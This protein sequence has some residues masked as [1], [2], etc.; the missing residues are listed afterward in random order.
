MATSIG[1]RS[2]LT[3][4]AVALTI[5][6]LVA[7]GSSKASSGASGTNN[8][9]APGVTSSEVKVAVIA[10]QTGPAAPTFA[11][12]LEGAKARFQMQNDAGGVKGRKVTVVVDDDQGDG[13]QQVVA[14]RNAVQSQKV[15]G[16]VAASRVDTM[17]DYLKQQNVP[18]TG[19][20]GQP[21]YATNMNTFGFAGAGP[22]GYVSTALAQR[23]K[24]SGATNVANLA[25]NSPGS[26]NS[27]KGFGVSA[28][29]IGLKIGVEQ[30]DIPLGSF[31]ATAVAIRMKQ[32]GIDAIQSATLTD[33]SV[34]VLK[35]L[36][37]QGVTLKATYVAGIYDPKVASQ[38]SDLIQGA[39]A[40]PVGIVPTELNTP[41]T[42]KYVDT[43]KK[44]EPSTNP[45]SGFTP[46]G[47]VSADLFI[48]GLE[49]AGSCL[50]R[51][52][53][54]EKLR[55]VTGYDGAGLLVKP[56]VFTAAEQATGSPYI[57]CSW[58]ATY[59]GTAWVPD[60][61]ATCGDLIKFS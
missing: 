38:I 11:G 31:D 1:R 61:T 33:S 36:R 48:R 56:A 41:A 24:D 10:P 16:V 55:T 17:Y 47:Y 59:K 52:N 6:A 49:A 20:P 18:V 22:T 7:C 43:M 57:K 37:A 12:F 60:P 54:V 40:T 27:A 13:A 2:V 46:A 19:Y 39:V 51:N 15:F 28:Q 14:A 45:N 35:A 3:T 5:P 25:H 26:I 9:D 30:W 34:S 4:A 23:M 53:F 21:A 32:A 44:Y 29:K 50:S 58:Y 8:C 42:T